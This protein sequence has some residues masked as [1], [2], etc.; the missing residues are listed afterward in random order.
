MVALAVAQI[1]KETQRS[2]QMHLNPAING[3]LKEGRCSCFYWIVSAISERATSQQ[4]AAGASECA[5]RL[6]CSLLPKCQGNHLPTLKPNAAVLCVEHFPCFLSF[7]FFLFPAD[8]FGLVLLLDNYSFHIRIF[9]SSLA[10]LF[11]GIYL[12]L[13][14]FFKTYCVLICIFVFQ[15][16]QTMSHSTSLFKY[17][18]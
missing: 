1:C 17:F 16:K 8:L 3:I 2:L 18:S 12:R 4:P 5:A 11:L 9:F 14:Y 13:Y 7:S 10:A 15:N 6:K